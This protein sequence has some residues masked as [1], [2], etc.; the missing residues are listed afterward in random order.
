MGTT[1]A[2]RAAVEA[3]L[4]LDPPVDSADIKV[5]NIKLC[6]SPADRRQQ[7]PALMPDHGGKDNR[8][9]ETVAMRPRYA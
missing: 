1:K 5:I 7:A 8:P 9:A 3:E 2:V 4:G 6:H